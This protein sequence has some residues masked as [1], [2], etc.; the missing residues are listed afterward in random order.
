MPMTTS[1]L[2]VIIL[3]LI[4]IMIILLCILGIMR[5]HVRCCCLYAYYEKNDTYKE[6]LLYF[7]E[8]GAPLVD[9][10][11][12]IIINGT[13]TLEIPRK[14]NI[15]VYSRENKGYDFGAYSFMIHRLKKK[16]DYYFFM[17]SSVRGPYMKSHGSSWAT[18]FL[19]LLNGDTRLVGTSIN[20]Y[21][22]PTLYQYDLSQLFGVKTVYSHVQ[23]MFFVM[24]HVLFTLL[25]NLI[26]SSISNP[27][28]KQNRI[29]FPF[30]SGSCFPFRLSY[31]FLRSFSSF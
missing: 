17:N 7:L 18:P 11:Y 22:Y 31:F 14:K 8:H 25:T 23:S 6:N 29:S 9:M 19:N 24:D 21:P 16:Y 15:H 10:D 1:A 28:D 27:R 20:I 30:K 2:V 5:R 3:I 26:P 12:Y 4:V 13:C